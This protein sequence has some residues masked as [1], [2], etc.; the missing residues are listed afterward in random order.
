MWM[1]LRIVKHMVLWLVVAPV[2]IGS[3]NAYYRGWPASWRAADWGSAGLL[4]EAASVPGAQV[5]ILATRA[6]NW[7]SIFAEH[8]ALVLKP[9]GAAQWTRYDVVGWG[10]PVRR[11]AYVADAQWYGNRPYLVARIEGRQAAALIPAIEAAIARY[12]YQGRGSYTAWPGPNSNS[13]VAWVVRNSEGFAVELP[14]VAVGKDYLGPGLQVAA[15]PSRTGYTVQAWGLIGVT[16]ALAEGLEINILGTAI[17][18]DPG[19]L[20]VKLAAL[21]KVGAGDLFN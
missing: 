3:A 6:G 5:M 10:T 15:A 12:P 16:A 1:A 7:K 14:P 18:I 8:M 11:D 20:S 9:A 2:A 13:F 19:E 21:G 17:G 4:P